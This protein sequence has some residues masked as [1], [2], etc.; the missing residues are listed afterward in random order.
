MIKKLDLHDLF[1]L[2]AWIAGIAG[3]LFL[4]YSMDVLSRSIGVYWDELWDYIPSVAL[5]RGDSLSGHQEINLFHHPVPLVSGPYQGALKTWLSAPLIKLFGGSP[6]FLLSLNVIF[7]IIYLLALYWALLPAIGRWAWVVFAS[8]LLDTNFLLIAPMDFGPS[9]FQ[10]ISI[11]LAMG[12]LFRYL[13]DRD[14]AYY[15]LIWFFSG[16]VLAQKL[17]AVPVV[18]SLMAVAIAF[19][20]K[21]FWKFVGG[22]RWPA[23]VKAYGIVPAILFLI[24]LVPHLLYFWRS[25][26]TDLFSMTT[27]GVRSPYFAALAENFKYVSTMFDGADWHQRIA[28]DDTASASLPPVLFICV[29]ALMLASA[30]IYFTS[31]RE[32]RLGTHAIVSTVLMLGS[33]VLFPVFRGLNRPWHFWI[34]TPAFA[35][36]FIIS[37][38]ACLSFLANRWRKSAVYFQITFGVCLALG[39]ASSAAHGL[40]VLRKIDHKKG[41]CL[42]SPAI[43]EVYHS[44]R[45]ADIKMI[46]GVNYS[47]ASPIYVLSKGTIRADELAW[48]DLTKDKIDEMLN[49]VRSD[50]EVGMVYRF[51]GC[52]EGDQ[53]WIR[54][55]NRDPQIFEL[56]KRVEAEDSTLDV[57]TIR[58][59]R[60]TRFVVIRKPRT[61]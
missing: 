39:V 47:L 55:L 32:K 22:H 48:T 15:R 31:V 19:S 4:L 24:P 49:R 16:C 1:R 43:T 25:G 51:C 38:A 23:A 11:S 35:C 36:C 5:I 41:A 58:D 20:C 56:I 59:E 45:A 21:P 29:L 60:E 14:R 46:Y 12:A 13:G 30:V 54:W 34:L 50:P 61:N 42:T 28:L 40:G 17:T 8:P 53:N 27:D 37:S 10:F 44:L 7:A 52:K 3:M 57:R 6:H 26:F 18:L 33:F 2:P 9:L